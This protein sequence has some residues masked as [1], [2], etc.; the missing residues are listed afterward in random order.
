MSDNEIE[1]S[2]EQIVEFP[3]PKS[4]GRKPKYN[5]EEERREAKRQQNKRYRTKK[6]EELIALRRAVNKLN[7]SET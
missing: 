6:H 4:R 7:E 3:A 2:T 5:T 1:M